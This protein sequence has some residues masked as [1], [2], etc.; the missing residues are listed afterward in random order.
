MKVKAKCTGSFTI[1]LPKY[2][3]IDGNGFREVEDTAF[4]R[5]Q[6]LGGKAVLFE[7][8]EEAEPKKPEEPAP[9][10]KRKN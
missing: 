8:K 6:I 1:L 7:E 9:R 3:F 2:E 5:G 4:L 10:K